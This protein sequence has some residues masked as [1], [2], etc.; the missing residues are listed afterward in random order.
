M[1]RNVVTL[2]PAFELGLWNAWIFVLPFV[3]VTIV[4]SR[5]IVRAFF[6]TDKKPAGYG[7]LHNPSGLYNEQEKKLVYIS[8]VI[9][10]ALYICSIFL[11]LRLGTA[12]FYIGFVIFL[13]GAILGTVAQINFDTTPINEPITKG[14]YRISRNPM[15]FGQFLLFMGIGVACISW[16]YLLTAVAHMIL[17]DILIVAEER[18]CL[19]KYGDAYRKYMN[20]TPRWIG[21]PKSKSE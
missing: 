7:R 9:T 16:I 17:G 21:M 1:E 3:F 4:L 13:M 18:W 8:M 19:E 6:T 5:L 15:Y 12:W 11:P 14:A 10:F 2:T 20:R